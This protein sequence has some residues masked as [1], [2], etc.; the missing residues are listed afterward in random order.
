[1]AATSLL[2]V[3]TLFPDYQMLRGAIATVAPRWACEHATSAQGAIAR[4][5]STRPPPTA[6]VCNLELNDLPGEV[7]YERL[8]Q[9]VPRLRWVLLADELPRLQRLRLGPDTICLPKPVAREGYCK[10]AAT[11]LRYIDQGTRLVP[12]IADADEAGS[13][14]SFSRRVSGNWIVQR[15]RREG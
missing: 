5:L 10:L 9:A 13:A 3:E 4:L 15:S 6:V 14:S 7:L 12:T 1:M 8:S 2:I 11:L